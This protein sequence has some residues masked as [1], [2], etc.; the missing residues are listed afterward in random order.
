MIVQLP[1]PHKDLSPNARIHWRKRSAVVKSSR[2]VACILAKEA[3]AAQME[4]DTLSAIITFHPPDKRRR[5][6]DNMIASLKSACDGIAD[7]LGVDDSKWIPTYHVG[8]PVK[9]GR[10]VVHFPEIA[11]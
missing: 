4:A 3:G 2:W 9:G 1:W 8:E 7:A 10:V 11:T 5:D 6:R